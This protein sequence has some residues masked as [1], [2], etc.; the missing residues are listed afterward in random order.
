MNSY[1][2]PHTGDTLRIFISEESG[3]G[4]YVASVINISS[5]SDGEVYALVKLQRKYQ[6]GRISPNDLNKKTMTIK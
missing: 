5:P 6:N 1:D 4:Y 2:I 3:G